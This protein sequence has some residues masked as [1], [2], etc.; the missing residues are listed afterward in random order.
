MARRPPGQGRLGGQLPGWL[1]MYDWR[2]AT[3]SPLHM[4]ISR[5]NNAKLPRSTGG[6]TE[7]MSHGKVTARKTPNRK[8]LRLII[9][10]LRTLPRR[11]FRWCVTALL[12]HPGNA[13]ANGVAAIGAGPTRATTFEDLERGAGTL[14]NRL[15]DS[16]IAEPVTDTNEHDVHF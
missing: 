1:R 16:G 11:L 8:V 2:V 10:C 5:K 15:V 7:P 6:T 4:R 9:R 12:D 13:A 14:G 3:E